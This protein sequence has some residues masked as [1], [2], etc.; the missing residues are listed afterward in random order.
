LF[1]SSV[2]L[3]LLFNSIV[4]TSLQANEYAVVPV[5]QDWQA[6]DQTRWDTSGLLDFDDQQKEN[7]SYTIRTQYTFDPLSKVTLRNGSEMDKYIV[8]PT[9]ECFV[10]YDTQYVSA[11]GNLYLV[12]KSPTVMRNLNIWRLQRYRDGSFEWAV[13]T[14]DSDLE[15]LNDHAYVIE[16]NTDSRIPFVS[17]PDM[18]PSNWWRC[19]SHTP[20]CK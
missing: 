1:L 8:L 3:H 19:P 14:K 13:A 12:Q 9:T 5:T 2:P 16:S 11:V 15:E 18:Y 6:S 7:V 4:F 20:T 10:A 17:R